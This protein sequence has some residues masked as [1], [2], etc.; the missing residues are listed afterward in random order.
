MT[1]KRIGRGGNCLAGVLLVVALFGASRDNLAL[2]GIPFM[3]AW[4]WF[5]FTTVVKGF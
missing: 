4:L 1:Q 2:A 5:A 3:A